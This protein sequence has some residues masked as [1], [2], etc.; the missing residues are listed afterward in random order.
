MVE[1]SASAKTHT[2]RERTRTERNSTFSMG[3]LQMVQS[4]FWRA[5]IDL[6]RH[7][8]CT[9]ALHAHA[10]RSVVSSWH[11]KHCICVDKHALY[12]CKV[13]YGNRSRKP[14]PTSTGAGALS[15]PSW[16]VSGYGFTREKMAVIATSVL[17]HM[18]AISGSW[19]LFLLR[20]AIGF[21]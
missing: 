4:V 10:H 19:P 8:R 15:S 7:A 13:C 9:C 11:T 14:D 3:C 12:S 21:Q 17:M 2:Q 20:S 18:F 16:M 5:S 1:A 6:S